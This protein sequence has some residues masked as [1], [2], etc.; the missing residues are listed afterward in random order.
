MLDHVIERNALRGFRAAQKQSG[1]AAGDETLRHRAKQ[2]KSEDGENQTDRD[3]EQRM[4][5]HAAQRP[6]VELQHPVVEAF[7]KPPPTE[8]ANGFASIFVQGAGA[9]VGCFQK[10]ARQHRRQR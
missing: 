4:L 2:I 5:E 1:I 8:T 7:S 10:L 9:N 6:F 3:R